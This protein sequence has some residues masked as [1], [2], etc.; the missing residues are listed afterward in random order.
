M[1]GNKGFFSVNHYHKIAVIRTSENICVIT[2][3]LNSPPDLRLSSFPKFRD[4]ENE[5][6]DS[7]TV[8]F[9]MKNIKSFIF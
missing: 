8:G 3:S 5:K 1:D 9:S 2:K 7:F 4:P 6:R